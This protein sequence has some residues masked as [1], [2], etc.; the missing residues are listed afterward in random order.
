MCVETGVGTGGVYDER[1]LFAEEKD[2]IAWCDQELIRVKGLRQAEELKRRKNKKN[3]PCIYGKRKKKE[4][5]K[6]DAKI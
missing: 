6:D 2:A 1:N 4:A 5:V 3:E